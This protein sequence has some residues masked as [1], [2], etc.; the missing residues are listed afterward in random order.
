MPA[1]ARG[2]FERH[3]VAL[4]APALFADLL[5]VAYPQST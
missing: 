2:W 4:D 1:S 5:N 3:G